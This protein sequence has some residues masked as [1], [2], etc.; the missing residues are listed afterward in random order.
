VIQNVGDMGYLILF[1]H[2]S[3]QVEINIWELLTAVKVKL[4]K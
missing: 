1:D 3:R 4:S 2:L